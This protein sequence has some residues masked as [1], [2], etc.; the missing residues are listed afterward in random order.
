M[1]IYFYR[2]VINVTVLTYTQSIG[3]LP[4]HH[5]IFN[6]KSS[7]HLPIKMCSIAIALLKI[8]WYNIRELYRLLRQRSLCNQSNGVRKVMRC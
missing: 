6:A 3:T 4:N 5:F 2:F 8:T 1:V 7:L